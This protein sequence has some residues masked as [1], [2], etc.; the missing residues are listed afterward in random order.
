MTVRDVRTERQEVYV[1]DIR[2]WAK[3]ILKD[4]DAN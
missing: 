2:A 4:L 3:A 1:E